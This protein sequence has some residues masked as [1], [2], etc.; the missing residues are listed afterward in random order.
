VLGTYLVARD[1]KTRAWLDPVP[2]N[3]ITTSNAFVNGVT[4]TL[5]RHAQ[6]GELHMPD[7]VNAFTLV[8]IPTRGFW[9]DVLRVA[10]DKL[11]FTS[12]AA[13]FVGGLE[14]SVQGSGANVAWVA[15]SGGAEAFAEG[16]RYERSLGGDFVVP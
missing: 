5:A 15:H 12:D 13:K 7:G 9:G 4:G 8:N 10:G 1:P 6:L 16:M 11:G 3:G 2:S 14:A